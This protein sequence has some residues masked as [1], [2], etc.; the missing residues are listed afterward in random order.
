MFLKKF[1]PIIFYYDHKFNQC[2]SSIISQDLE[3][4]TKFKEKLI[5]LKSSANLYIKQ[6]LMKDFNFVFFLIPNWKSSST[7][8]ELI[9]HQRK[10]K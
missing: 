4:P 8:T 3:S 10:L 2:S 9:A 7:S 6:N 5:S 1:N